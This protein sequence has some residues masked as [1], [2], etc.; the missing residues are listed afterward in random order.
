MA[1]VFSPP[2]GSVFYQPVE[3]ARVATRGECSTVAHRAE[4]CIAMLQAVSKQ[5]V[6]MHI[7]KVRMEIDLCTQYPRRQLPDARTGPEALAQGVATF[8]RKGRWRAVRCSRRRQ[9]SVTA[10][11]VPGCRMEISA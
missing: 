6:G 5:V 2:P 10:R 4:F 7:Q 8:A 3:E 1:C 9:R 11:G